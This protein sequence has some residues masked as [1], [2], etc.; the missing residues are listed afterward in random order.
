MTSQSAPTCCSRFQYFLG[1]VL[2]VGG[3]GLSAYAYYVEYQ[4]E[5][6][7][8]NRQQYRPIYYGNQSTII[9]RNVISAVRN[10][11]FL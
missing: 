10:I 11:F 7:P 8:G 9:I 1:L 3:I 2:Y 5:T 4:L 6:Q